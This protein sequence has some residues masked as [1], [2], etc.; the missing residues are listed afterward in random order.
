MNDNN[1]RPMQRGRNR[2]VPATEQGST[3]LVSSATEEKLGPWLARNWG[4]LADTP[5]EVLEQ[6]DL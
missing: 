3:A 1:N 4:I 2:V 6:I 5:F